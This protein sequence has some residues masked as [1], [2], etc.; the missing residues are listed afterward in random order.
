MTTFSIIC[1]V[2][3]GIATLYQLIQVIIYAWKIRFPYPETLEDSHLPRFAV[4]MPLRGADPFLS[5]AIDH[6]LDQDYPD[7]Q[8]HF[9]IDHPS[10]P[11][12]KVVEETISRR[13]ADNVHISFVDPSRETCSLLCNAVQQFA[14]ELDEATEL[15][16]VC[17]ADVVLPS[18]WL[19]IAATAMQDPTVGATLGNRWYMPRVGKLGSLVRYIWNTA[20]NI[21][22]F[23]HQGAWSGAMALRVKDIHRLNFS[24][25]WLRSFTEDMSV[26]KTLVDAGLKLKHVPHLI[27]VNREEIS[28]QG[29]FHFIQ[30]Q[31]FIARFHHPKGLRMICDSLPLSLASFFNL[32]IFM[33]AI[34][35]GNRQAAIYSGT[36]LAASITLLGFSVLLTEVLVRR[37]MKARGEETTVVSFSAIMLFPIALL[38]CQ[39]QYLLAIPAAL[40]TQRIVW[41]GI[42]YDVNIRNKEIRMLD[43]EPYAPP[44]ML[45][46]QPISI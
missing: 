2:V 12:L 26:A 19:R 5:E 33:I 28:V 1:S 18:N 30:R 35:N 11:A 7:F 34:F 16:L 20:A 15:F 14:S 32:V 44:I 4:L 24:D 40:R 29:N 36:T 43:Y 42:T 25:V 31:F 17:A 38:M 39:I 37:I 9:V 21:S 41:R 3:L 46:E 10:D 13:N 6:V 45:E 8:L 27:A 22:M 23:R